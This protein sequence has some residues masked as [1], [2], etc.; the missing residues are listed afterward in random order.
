MAG[1]H[2]MTDFTDDL[3]ITEAA[4]ALDRALDFGGENELAAWARKWGRDAMVG[5][6]E[7]DRLNELADMESQLAD[8]EGDLKAAD[9]NFQALKDDIE[10]HLDIFE[11]GYNENPEDRGETVARHI[12]QLRG[13]IA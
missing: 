9:E 12:R 10:N 5:L 4:C 8:A 6:R 2:Q 1:V 3:T 11:D 13:L 7:L